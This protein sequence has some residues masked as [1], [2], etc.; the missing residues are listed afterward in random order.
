MDTKQGDEGGRAG[1][2]KGPPVDESPYGDTTI[3]RDL[4]ELERRAGHLGAGRRGDVERAP[5]DG[6]DEDRSAIEGGGRDE[7][8]PDTPDEDE[9]R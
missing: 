1:E 7:L 3:D 9:S 2:G 4:E 8:R 6:G 5:E